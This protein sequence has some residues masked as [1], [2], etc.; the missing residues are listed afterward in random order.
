MRLLRH[1]AV[2]ALAVLV[3][4]VDHVAELRG[5]AFARLH[6]QV[7]G[8]VSARGRGILVVFVHAHAP[9]GVDA[10]PDLENDVVDG[11]AVVLQTAD[12]DDRKQSFRR[13]AVEPYEAVVGQDAVFVHEGHD[14][15]GDAHHQQVQQRR[16]LLEGYA[17]ALCIGLHQLETY[18]AAR[19]LVERVGAIDP[20]GVQNGHGLRDFVGREMVVADDEIHAF[21]FRIDDLFH[22]L[23]SAVEGDDERDAFLRRVIDAFDRDAVAFGV[24]VWNVER[25]VAVSD[26]AEE[27]VHE[28]H[29][30]AAVH[31]VIAVHHDLLAVAHGLRHAFHR[32]FHVFHQ[33]RIVQVGELRIKKLLCSFYCVYAS[34]YE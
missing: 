17:V 4:G 12:L 27:L 14:V 28:R 13:L 9:C 18:A 5:H 26:V 21:L 25:Q 22:G 34:L 10:G 31:V 19:Q 32:A 8:R 1:A 30:R 20:L 3:V 23:D 33:K 6:E 16:E 11:D 2:D 7:H 24:P 29:G 15:R